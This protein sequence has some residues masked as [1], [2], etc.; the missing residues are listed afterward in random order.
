VYLN[1]YYL[2]CHSVKPKEEAKELV[3]PLRTKN[4]WILPTTAADGLDRQAAEELVK[5]IIKYRW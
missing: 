4:R 5:G 1:G 2:A 3:I